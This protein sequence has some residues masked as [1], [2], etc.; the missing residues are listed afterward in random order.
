MEFPFTIVF[1]P[2]S[3][4]EL[5]AV[6]RLR[7]MW[8]VCGFL[9]LAV[10]STGAFL[11]VGQA[12]SAADRPRAALSIDT[13]S[14]PATVW[15]DGKQIGPAPASLELD[16]G[17][18]TVTLAAPAALDAPYTVWTD[19]VSAATFVPHPWRRQPAVARVHSLLP[20][21]ELADV[22]PLAD[23]DLALTQLVR[24][25]GTLQAWRVAPATG[26]ATALLESSPGERL[27]VSADGAHIALIGRDVGPLP[28][29]PMASG[30]RAVGQIV[31]LG[32]TG[33]LNFDR[34][35]RPPLDDDEAL[36]EVSW[37]R[38]GDALLVLAARGG[39]SARSRVWL[40]DPGSLDARQILT[41][42]SGVAT[43]TVAWSP[44]GH[45]VAF[46]AH[47][48]T[49]NAL[50]MLDLGSARLRYLADL[51]PSSTAQLPYP[52]GAWS[53][54]GAAFA[55]VA[56]RRTDAPP[57]LLWPPP[58]AGHGLFLA[59]DVEHEPELV[60]HTAAGYPAWR[61]DGQ[62]VGLG[63]APSDGRLDVR[64]LDGSRARLI[65]LPIHVT[66]G[67]A[68]MWDVDHGHLLVA[69]RKEAGLDVLL[70]RLGLE[71]AL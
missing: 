65:E 4:S 59:R 18:H 24:G 63:R 40:L 10:G 21:A 26:S 36:S 43:G 67:F 2:P 55:F 49:L 22:R 60:V 29:T 71:E 7:G 68:G 50:C 62:L 14:H 17:P 28:V 6:L 11:S 48:G 20:G 27:A 44:D 53:P 5:F 47:G 46:V 54:D 64:L 12:A 3:Q 70:V 1:E 56:P 8:L 45:R 37:N 15:V 41:L 61:E 13:T 31:W 33:R 35:W 32:N 23:G 9:T 52:V 57:S 19:G 51:D 30:Q 25:E 16:A 66:P 38:Q 42:P 34:G 58:D 69:D 39:R